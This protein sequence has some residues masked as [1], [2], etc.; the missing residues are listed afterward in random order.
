MARAGETIVN[1]VNR[2]RL[3]FLATA[4]DTDGELLRIEHVFE[5]GGFVPA[6][7]IHPKQE[8]RLEV[9]SGSPR[10]RIVE[11][12]RAAEPGDVLTVPPGTPHTWWNA[13]NEETRMLVEFRPAF[14]T[15]TLFETL[16][17]LARDGKLNKRGAP[18]PLLAAVLVK[19][20]ADE[21]SVAPQKEFL[22][23]RLPPSLIRV[24]IAVL[25]PLGGLLGYRGRYTRY[26]SS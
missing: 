15:E 23:S 1:P 11:S 20:Y 2:E 9:L 24:L 5:P 13:G 6:A 16:Y 21:V 26:T 10:F 22:L 3:T 14:R 17:G 25:A 19:E 18:N 7:H 4:R 8:E 12:E